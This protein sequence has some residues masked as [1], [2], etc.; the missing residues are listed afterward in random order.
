LVEP[1][2][3]DQALFSLAHGAGRKWKRGECKGRLSHKYKKEDLYRTGLGSRVICGDKELL[4]DEAPEAYKD[5]S[6]IIDDLVNAGLVEVIAKLKPVLTFKTMESC[7][8]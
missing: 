1:T 6:S 5:C 3:S 7:H 2:A 4:Y 8:G